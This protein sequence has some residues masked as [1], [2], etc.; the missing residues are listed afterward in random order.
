MKRLAGFTLIEL[1]IA[2]AIVGIL[3]AIAY[4]SYQGYVQSARRADAQADLLELA[5]WM[6]R[7]FTVNGNYNSSTDNDND[8]DRDDLPFQKSPV[9][10]N[11]T[12]YNIT[13]V[14][15]ATTFTLT[16]TRAGAQVGDRCGNMTVNQTGAKTAAQNDC[17]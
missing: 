13:V 10:G 16:A 2:V 6:E 11:D 5:Q 15:A 14:G 8:F 3:T 17:W 4:P 9:D 12:F 1:M 7:Q